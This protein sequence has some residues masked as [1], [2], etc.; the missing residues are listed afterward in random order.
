MNEQYISICELILLQLLLGSIIYIV[1][2]VALFFVL[3]KTVNCKCKIFLLLLVQFC[4]SILLS[5]VIWKFW[6]INID[7]MIFE[8]INLPALFCELITI[9]ICYF[10]LKKKKGHAPNRKLSS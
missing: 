7:V 1:G 2:S 9:P 5:L 10:V 6:V 8:F 3:R 4:V